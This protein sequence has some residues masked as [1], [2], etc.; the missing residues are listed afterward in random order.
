MVIEA[1]AGHDR[2][3]RRRQ[4]RIEQVL[5]VAVAVMAEQ[6]V[7]GLTL[8]EVARRMRIRPP[9][10]YVYFASKNALYDALF[11]RG[12]RELLEAVQPVCEGL[13]TATDLRSFLHE[14]SRVFVRW[15]VEH[16][17][18]PPLMFWRPVPGFVPSAQAYAP[19][20]ELVALARAMLLE[21]RERGLLAPDADLD[22]AFQA[23]TVVTT[24]P[25]TQQ[26]ANAPEQSIEDGRFTTTLPTVIDMWLSQ[27]QT[28]GPLRQS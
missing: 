26:L 9:S 10:L 5:D 7:A 19:A 17:A 2:R 3:H 12:W 24:G 1:R 13:P 22:Q 16:P 23:F 15:A 14:Y 8:G 20:V 25:I 4:E 28:P 21:L 18:Y 6:G 27:Y 11:A